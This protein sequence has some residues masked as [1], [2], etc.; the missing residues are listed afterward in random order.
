MTPYSVYLLLMDTTLK[1]T[2]LLFEDKADDDK[3]VDP[4]EKSFADIYKLLRWLPK[5]SSIWR[6]A[7]GTRKKRFTFLDLDRW[8]HRDI[9][10]N[11]SISFDERSIYRYHERKSD[12]KAAKQ[13]IHI[14]FDGPPQLKEESPKVYNRWFMHNAADIFLANKDKYIGRLNGIRHD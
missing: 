3:P 11:V 14:S 1:L 4:T 10:K 12:G 5:V 8:F 7:F 13:K 2:T 6:A 9:H